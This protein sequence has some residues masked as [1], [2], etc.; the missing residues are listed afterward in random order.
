MLDSSNHERC[1]ETQCKWQCLFPV[2]SCS[3]ASSSPSVW[4]G[5]CVTWKIIRPW[6]MC[7]L[8]QP[9]ILGSEFPFCQPKIVLTA[10]CVLKRKYTSQGVSPRDDFHLCFFFFFS[11]LVNCLAWSISLAFVAGDQVSE[12]VAELACRYLWQ[13]KGMWG[14][15]ARSAGV[16]VLPWGGQLGDWEL[17]WQL[18]Q[19]GLCCSVRPPQALNSQKTFLDASPGLPKYNFV[20]LQKAGCILTMDGL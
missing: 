4:P 2:A 15:A 14:L 13:L 6:E 3:K 16:G 11:F 10:G 9:S 18:Q 19:R 8:S 20:G 17:C 5:A 7:S 1:S 12:T